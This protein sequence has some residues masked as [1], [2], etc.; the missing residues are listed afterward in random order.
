VGLNEELRDAIR[1]ELFHAVQHSYPALSADWNVD[2]ADWLFEGTAVAAERSGASMIHSPR[3]DPRVIDLILD[4]PY[5]AGTGVTY[6]V[7]YFWVHLGQTLGQPLSYL[8]GIFEAGGEPAEVDGALED[9]LEDAYWN[10]VKNQIYEKTQG[11]LDRFENGPCELEIELANITLIGYGPSSLNPLITNAA[12]APLAA[13]VYEVSF[14]EAI[15]GVSVRVLR[16]GSGTQFKI[17]KE[18]EGGCAS[19]PDSENLNFDAQG[20][21]TLYVV[22]AN[23]SHEDIELHRLEIRAGGE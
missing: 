21:D 5:Q 4:F 3:L 1:H 9:K 16:G 20:G 22:V 14:M 19:I 15:A 10:W 17:Y 23:S 18:G 13:T 8:T 12:W 2:A 11:P 7:Q 6:Q